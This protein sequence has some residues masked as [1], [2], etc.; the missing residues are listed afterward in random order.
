[1][2]TFTI[3][4]LIKCAQKYTCSTP[5]TLLLEVRRQERA[6]GRRTED[7]PGWSQR[8]VHKVVMVPFNLPKAVFFH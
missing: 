1:M 4:Q 3:P 2:V 5:G 6:R 7:A 8:R